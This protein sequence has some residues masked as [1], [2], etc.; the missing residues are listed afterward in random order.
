MGEALSLLRLRKVK[1]SW[2]QSDKSAEKFEWPSCTE[3]DLWRSAQVTAA[4]LQILW[5]CMPFPIGF[6]SRNLYYFTPIVLGRL[7]V[8]T[9]SSVLSTKYSL[10]CCWPYFSVVL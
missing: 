6:M 1:S 8:A 3:H 4:R 7:L 10:P 5:K 2:I 9:A